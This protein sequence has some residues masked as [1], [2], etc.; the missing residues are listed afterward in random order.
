MKVAFLGY[1][2]EQTRLIAELEGAGC[3]VEQTAHNVEDLSGYDLVVSFGFKHIIRR[4]CIETARRPILNLHISLLPFNRGYHPNFWAHMEGT[5]H[6]V[7]IHEIDAGV[8]T[9][10]LVKQREVRFAPELDSF[11]AT[12]EVLI[13]D[14]EELFIENLTL[15]LDSDYPTRAQVGDGSFHRKSQLPVWM[16]DW[17]MPIAEARALFDAEKVSAQK[18]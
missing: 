16:T 6:G 14:V 17:T 1:S 5:P 15:L 4:S 2:R 8:D 11:W 18:R 13:R 7:T 9:G 12:Y 10:K 3:V